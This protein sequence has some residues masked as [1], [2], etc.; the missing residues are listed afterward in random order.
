MLAVAAGVCD[1]GA[2][3]DESAMDAGMA[4]GDDDD[5]EMGITSPGSG[6]DV[7]L[8]IATSVG[9]GGE[10]A[11]GRSGEGRTGARAGAQE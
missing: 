1:G 11:R 3:E 6:F 2:F 10:P 4:C 7:E 8:P 9:C 5:E